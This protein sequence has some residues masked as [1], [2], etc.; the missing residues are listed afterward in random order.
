M[1][2]QISGM[3]EGVASA[4][5]LRY[6]E[7]AIAVFFH[8]F[9]EFERFS[10]GDSAE[11]RP[12]SDRSMIHKFKLLNFCGWRPVQDSSSTKESQGHVVTFP[13]FC[14]EMLAM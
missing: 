9:G 2:E 13:M 7:R 4:A 8:G 3:G 11:I 5:A 1:T 12:D 14:I 10:G 6:P